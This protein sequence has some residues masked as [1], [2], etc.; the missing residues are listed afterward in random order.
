MR[1]EG[2]L[3][4][5]YKSMK[6]L[7]SKAKN[8]EELFEALVNAPFSDKLQTTTLDLGI[9]VL[10]LANKKTKT[11]DRVALSKT[12]HAD[13]ALRMTPIPFH[14]IKIPIGYKTNTIA[15]A[16]KTGVPQRTNDWKFLFVPALEPEAARFNQAGAGIA[17]SFVYPFTSRDGGTLIFSYYQP[18]DHISDRHYAFM[19]KY[20]VMAGEALGE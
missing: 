14:D 6:T 20:S 8:D 12:E 7:L 3:T 9:V 4:E 16:I 5:Y 15:V 13:W 10:L 1:S 11:I 17:C 18:F 2:S 19:E